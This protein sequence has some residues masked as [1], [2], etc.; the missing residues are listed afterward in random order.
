MAFS[1]AVNGSFPLTA[2]SQNVT[3]SSG[4]YI[5]SHAG[6][7]ALFALFLT[8]LL[9]LMA[10]LPRLL[11][12]YYL[13]DFSVVS[14]VL[15]GFS[16]WQNRD[17]I[18]SACQGLSTVPQLT[19]RHDVAETRECG[20]FFHWQLRSAGIKNHKLLRENEAKDL[21]VKK[22]LEENEEKDVKFK[23][24][25]KRKDKLVNVLEEAGHEEKEWQDLSTKLEAAERREKDQ[26][27]RADVIEFTTKRER[28]YG[29]DLR[30]AKRALEKSEIGNKQLRANLEAAKTSLDDTE[31]S[32]E[33]RKRKYA[34]LSDRNE[35]MTREIDELKAESSKNE[36]KAKSLELELATTKRSLTE[37][38]SKLRGVQ[39][40][41]D[42]S[43]RSSEDNMAQLDNAQKELDG[44]KKNLDDTQRDLASVNDEL[45]G[46]RENSKRNLAQLK[47][48]QG[49]LK[50]TE[51]DLE[52]VRDELKSANGIL[53]TKDSMIKNLETELDENKEE[54]VGLR[55]KLGEAEV[56]AP[57]IEPD[58]DTMKIWEESY[59]KL[60][61]KYHETRKE[62]DASQ[63]AHEAAKSTISGLNKDLT[64]RNEEIKSLSSDKAASDK[65]NT[66]VSGF[67]GLFF[68][69]LEAEYRQVASEEDMMDYDCEEKT[70]AP[71]EERQLYDRVESVFLL[72]KRIL[73]TRLDATTKM[74]EENQ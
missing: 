68:N 57:A 37:K 42:V 67:L 16:L 46:E 50:T 52:S 22:L 15:F 24:L 8:L 21:E 66:D 9:G 45:K 32:I 27:N 20:S 56:A 61:K 41:L 3:T 38:D 39:E 47:E 59:D 43:N 18:V 19:R 17:R 12:G 72:T 1:P 71:F 4:S 28:Q 29:A 70:M 23:D 2:F 30:N 63:E 44:T 7:P 74:A 48:S 49:K 35:L 6:L 64:T 58:A 65:Q 10:N 14:V 25:Q 51:M 53:E 69:Y 60:D 11:L 40:Q 33:E 26:K 31:A 73:K 54:V 34:T 5:P 13:P 36:Q 62:L 55:K